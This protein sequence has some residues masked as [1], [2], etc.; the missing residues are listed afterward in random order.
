MRIFFSALL[1][2]FLIANF[3]YS[4]QNSGRIYNAFSGTL[5]LSVEAGPTFGQTDYTK[6]KIDYL[7][8]TSL[9][10][11]FPAYSKSSFGLRAFG[12]GGY[13]GGTDASLAPDVFRTKLTFLGGGIVYSLSL[14]NYVFPYLFAGATY[15]WFDPFQNNGIKMPNNLKDIYPKHEVNY[16][17]E[18]GFRFL[19]TS[20]L[21]FNLTGGIQLSPNDYLDDAAIGTNN[22]FFYYST[23]GFSF[24]FFGDHDSD[25]DGVPDSKDMCPNTPKGIKVDEFGCPLDSDHDGVPDYLDKCPNTP[26]GVQVD[27]D[28][29][30]LDS[31]GDGVP[32]YRDICPNT[33]K[34]VKV[35]DLG[36]PLDSDGDGVPDYLDKCPNTPPN[37]SVDSE[38]CPLDSDGDGV[39]DYL[40]KCPD[41]APGVKVDSTG[42]PVVTKPVQKTEKVIEEKP[43]AKHFTLS[44]GA[45]FAFGRSTLLPAA[46]PELDKLVKVMKETP[47]SFWRI[48]GYTDNIGTDK[49]NKKVSLERAQAVLNYFILKGL[50]KKRF[51]VLGLGK[52]HP[53]ASNAAEEGRAKNRRV[54]IIRI[55]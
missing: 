29:C 16:N 48:E 53:I 9:E 15:L 4:Q 26:K 46:Y 39:P 51:Q 34:G 18:L 6:S 27:K 44:A 33:P 10:Y 8:R 50:N 30:P 42:C 31:D 1:L 52:A 43:E 23:A 7:G 11:F 21:S 3:S 14:G 22:D 40:D 12:G 55:K 2:F 17:S 49:A 36:C 32:D 24:S 47:Q 13:I 35:D 37:V 54:E 45:N 41:T 20:N 19:L 5:V 25:G 38:G 28:G